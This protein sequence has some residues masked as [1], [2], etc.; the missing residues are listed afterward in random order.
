MISSGVASN[1]FNRPRQVGRTVSPM[2]MIKAKQE[3][4]VFEPS[5]WKPTTNGTD[6]VRHTM[7]QMDR[8][9]VP[10]NVRNRRWG[11]RWP[12][13][14]RPTQLV[15]LSDSRVYGHGLFKRYPN[16]QI[17]YR[18]AMDIVE[19][20]VRKSYIGIPL[21]ETE[22]LATSAVFPDM[23]YKSITSEDLRLRAPISA[24]EAAILRKTI[25]QET[26]DMLNSMGIK[27]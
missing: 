16:G 19:K 20:A 17:D 15:E 13:D 11:T 27:L 24:S 12:A 14:N 9:Q 26:L 3:Y 2:D 8:S 4:E 10:L 23:R 22:A 5:D 7:G 18:Y 1:L 25:G 6:A 21:T